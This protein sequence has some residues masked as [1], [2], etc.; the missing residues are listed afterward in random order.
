MENTPASVRN[1]VMP[2][3]RCDVGRVMVG[4]WCCGAAPPF[5]LIDGNVNSAV[6]QK[7]LMEFIDRL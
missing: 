3:V 7:I 6:D 1:T 5:A 2:T 4:Q